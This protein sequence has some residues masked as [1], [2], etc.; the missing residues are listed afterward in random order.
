MDSLCPEIGWS[1]LVPALENRLLNFLEFCKT[2]SII[3]AAKGVLTLPK[4]ASTINQNVFFPFESQLLEICQS[5]PALI[6]WE[7]SESWSCISHMREYQ[8]LC[9][10]F[11]KGFLQGSFC[12]T[13]MRVVTFVGWLLLVFRGSSRLK[14]SSLCPQLLLSVLL[15]H[16]SSLPVHSLPK[17]VT[18]KGPGA[19]LVL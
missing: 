17:R 18:G 6:L 14:S 10:S 16:T 2:A 13:G 9:S 8:N 1:Q 12:F 11:W 7:S 5:T 3:L 4:L 19:V 15:L